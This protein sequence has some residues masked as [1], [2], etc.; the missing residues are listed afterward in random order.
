MRFANALHSTYIKQR[1]LSH[2]TYMKKAI[3][4]HDPTYTKQA[5][6]LG[7]RTQSSPS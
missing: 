5:I 2:P 4:P 6:Y 3:A 1:S 7:T